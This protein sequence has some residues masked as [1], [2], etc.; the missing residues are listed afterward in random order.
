VPELRWILLALGL[1]LIVGVFLW[2]RYRGSRRSLSDPRREPVLDSR[3][4]PWDEPEARPQAKGP[5]DYPDELLISE[6]DRAA[7]A[8]DAEP[9]RHEVG[10]ASEQLII[11]L[12]LRARTP[13]GFSGT[14]LLEACR[15]ERLE[16]GKFGAFHS[17]DDQGHSRFLIASLVEPGEFVLETMPGER[18]LGVSLFMVL[19]GPKEPLTA[20]DGML[21]CGRRLARRLDGELL[22]E[23]GTALTVQEA[24]WLR[25]QVVEYQRRIRL[26]TIVGRQPGG[27]P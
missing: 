5:A 27:Q 17:L 20:L 7:A 9:E 22:D 4:S 16:H 25:E 19:P 26:G 24:A 13:E 10:D 2:S 23:K 3:T 12:R 6:S 14:D 11:A 8:V 1:A 15:A 18:Y 21:A